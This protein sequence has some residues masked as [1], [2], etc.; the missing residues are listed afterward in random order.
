M[1]GSGDKGFWY[2]IHG[3][4]PDGWRYAG[5]CISDKKAAVYAKFIYTGDRRQLAEH[6]DGELNSAR[7]EVGSLQRLG[8]AA[9]VK[10]FDDGKTTFAFAREVPHNVDSEAVLTWFDDV[11]SK[12]DALASGRMERLQPVG[13]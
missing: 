11:F 2:G 7:E 8:Q 13:T 5:F 12:M 4:T 3:N 10:E 9:P 1:I 6:F